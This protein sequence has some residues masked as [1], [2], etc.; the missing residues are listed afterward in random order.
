MKTSLLFGFILLYALSVTVDAAKGGLS[1]DEQKKLLDEINEDRKRVNATFKPLTYD[2]ELEKEAALFECDNDK[3]P[4]IWLQWNSVAHDFW[5]EVDHEDNPNFELY[6][7]RVVK[8]GCSKETKCTQKL[9][10]NPELPEK[11]VGK[12]MV[13]LGA[14]VIKPIIGST[15]PIQKDFS[16]VPKGK[17]YGDVLG[18]EINSSG[19]VFNL[20][21]FITIILYDT[22]LEKKVAALECEDGSP[23]LLQWN[24]VV[25]DMWTEVTH[26]HNPNRPLFDSRAYLIGCSKEF[27]CTKKIEKH[28]E[29]PE[30]FVGKEAVMLGACYVGPEDEMSGEEQNKVPESS[31]PKGSK[32]G[33][34]LGLKISSSGQVFNLFVFLAIIV[35]YF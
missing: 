11:F 2:T 25:Q 31:I 32:Y 26:V 19:R 4:P 16:L 1:K 27:K 35:F 10:K 15:D 34:L 21:V 17:K 6:D 30:K 3:K 29:M 14:C 33:D 7:S 8:I 20:I 28:P 5:K 22:E 18:I 12:E 9:V 23:V 24:S 13:M